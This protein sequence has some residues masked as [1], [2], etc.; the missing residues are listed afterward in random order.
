MPER[1][2]FYVGYLPTM[3]PGLARRTRAVVTLGVLL[4]LGAGVVIAFSQHEYGPALF[5][6][7]TATT[8]RGHIV[9]QPYAQLVVQRPLEGK[10]AG[11][12]GESCYLLAAEWK[13][14]AGELVAGLEG[15]EVDVTGTLVH[16]GGRVLIEVPEGGIVLVD[17][18]PPRDMALRDDDVLASAT[19]MTVV[20]EIVDSKC[21]LG[22]MV[23]GSLKPHRACA[24]RCIAG[25]IPPVLYVRSASGQEL[26][27]G[28][29]LLVDADGGPVNDRVLDMV[30]EPVEITGEVRALGDLHVLYA[31]PETYRRL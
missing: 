30:A 14:G 1:D 12:S 15:A 17:G 16:R 6:F 29:V 22:V 18:A 21:W 28:F 31:D 3:A 5:E 10:A 25:G 27:S 24:T 26:G 23:P 7:G 19:T 11:V 8:V 13:R 9:E 4:M 2:E 20:G